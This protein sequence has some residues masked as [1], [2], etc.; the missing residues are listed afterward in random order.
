MDKETKATLIL[1]PI[2]L[3]YIVT[4]CIGLWLMK[5]NLI[6]DGLA[7]CIGFGLGFLLSMPFLYLYSRYS[8]KEEKK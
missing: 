6:D 4:F 7:L 3:I 5:Q 1:I 2:P 8:Q